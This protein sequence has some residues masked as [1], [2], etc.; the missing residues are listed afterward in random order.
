MAVNKVIILLNEA[1]KLAR[2]AGVD[3]LVCKLEAIKAYTAPRLNLSERK[4]PKEV[5]VVVTKPRRQRNVDTTGLGVQRVFNA[6]GGAFVTNQPWLAEFCAFK[7]KK[8]EEK[9]ATTGKPGMKYDYDE[10]TSGRANRIIANAIVCNYIRINNL[11][12]NEPKTNFTIDNDLARLLAVP[13]DSTCDYRTLQKLLELVFVPTP[14]RD[15]LKHF[16]ADPNCNLLD[17]VSA[18]RSTPM[19]GEE[20]FLTDEPL[21]KLLKCTVGSYYFS[22]RLVPFDRTCSVDSCV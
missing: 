7:N 12:M 9:E 1:Q 16:N 21:A 20:T 5:V 3:E 14:K 17:L 8:A 4:S 11:Q 13:R 22:A 15:V 6:I 10:I 2:D 19:I 18:Y